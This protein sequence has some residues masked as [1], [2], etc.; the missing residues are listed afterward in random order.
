MISCFR[1]QADLIVNRESYQ[2][3]V[4]LDCIPA[5]FNGAAEALELM[6]GAGE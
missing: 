6:A 4:R 2:D 1:N 3:L 5:R